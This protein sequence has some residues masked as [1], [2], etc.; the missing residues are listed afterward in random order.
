MKSKKTINRQITAML[1]ATIMGISIVPTT[2]IIA[3]AA[4]IEMATVGVSGTKGNVEWEYFEDT[5]TF[6][7]RPKEGYETAP[8]PDSAATDSAWYKYRTSIQ[9]VIFEDGITDIGAYTLSSCSKITE[10]YLPDSVTKIG[11]NAFYK[12]SALESFEMPDTVTTIGD[13][14][15]YKCSAL[16]SF[17]MPDTVT[18]IGDRAFGGCSNLKTI[19][20]SENLT[21]ISINMFYSCTKL[22]KITIP[23]NVTTIKNNA[24]RS[25]TS[26]VDVNILSKTAE[27]ETN[28]FNGCRAL[29][30][31]Y[32]Y[33]G[34]TAID[35]VTSCRF[36]VGYLVGNQNELEELCE[37]VNQEHSATYTKLTDDITIDQS[38]SKAFDEY[39]GEFDG[40]GH[41]IYHLQIDSSED[42]VGFIGILNGGTV[43]NLKITNAAI[44]AP[45]TAGNAGIIAGTVKNGAITG[46]EVSGEV[47]GNVIGGIVGETQGAEISAC[48]NKATVAGENIAGGIAGFADNK[49]IINNC[50]NKGYISSYNFSGG[51]AGNLVG[52][53]INSFNYGE[54][55]SSQFAGG[56]VG[57]L[58]LS[59]SYDNNFNIDTVEAAGV[60][61]PS[62]TENK[63][64]V[65]VNASQFKNGVVAYALNQKSEVWGQQL[66]LDDA[67]EMLNNSNKLYYGYA[68]CKSDKIYSNSPLSEQK[69]DLHNYAD[70]VC[71]ECGL[72]EKA[73]EALAGYALKLD[74]TLGLCYYINKDKVTA[75]SVIKF[76]IEGEQNPQLAEQTVMPIA[77]GNYYKYTCQIASKDM[78][79]EIKA[80]LIE[81]GEETEL[82]AYNIKRYSEYLLNNTEQNSIKA[83]TLVKAMLNYGANAQ[84]YFDFNMSNLANE[85]CRE[86]VKRYNLSAYKAK[87]E[88]LDNNV[89]F[90]GGSLVVEDNTSLKLY[91]KLN[92]I[93]NAAAETN[94][95]VNVECNN[96]ALNYNYTV[97][98]ATN[99]VCIIKIN[100]IS[101]DKL[102]SNFNVKMVN[103]ETGSYSAV[104]YSVFSYVYTVSKGDYKETTKN[105]AYSIYNYYLAT[106]E[107]QNA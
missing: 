39:S 57:N 8:I 38:W 65:T 51:I 84:S 74:G 87:K 75:D 105:L 22:E 58:N 3:G 68:D 93:S 94:Y 53:V 88:T 52:E 56:I 2:A 61:N 66:K 31:V 29:K 81:N 98:Y 82:A 63:S 104:D 43:K 47:T 44:T 77:E 27:Y 50:G 60:T 17:E 16:E 54:I 4:E 55:K 45:I 48:L 85:S 49:T 11:E 42:N 97:D 1:M 40:C 91:F 86:E 34:S 99:G 18:T 106:C 37:T 59:G 101:A 14:A 92:G 30:R 80:M 12:C 103:N 71:S 21:S 89:S 9:K 73:N 25:C 96:S 78:T 100:G 35:Y 67:P 15:F 72:S 46:C 95:T 62:S 107:Y 83:W 23:E 76:N 32:T 64:C 41:T 36:Q 5:G 7:F 6:I 28:V 26:L 102:N 24:F 90:Y 79:A 33:D 10:V 19:K 69:S 20:L 13:E 70:G